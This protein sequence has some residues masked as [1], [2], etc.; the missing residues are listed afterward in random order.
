MMNGNNMASVNMNGQIMNGTLL[1]RPRCFA[2][3]LAADIADLA[4]SAAVSGCNGDRHM[5]RAP[6]R[7]TVL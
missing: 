4:L 7:M 5:K 6:G 2:A 1:C 3:Q